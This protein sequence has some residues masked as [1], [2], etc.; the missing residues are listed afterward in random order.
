MINQVIWMN[1]MKDDIYEL[2]SEFLNPSYGKKQLINEVAVHVKEFFHASF[3]AFYIFNEQCNS[4]QLYT[5]ATDIDTFIPKDRVKDMLEFHSFDSPVPMKMKTVPITVF[6][7]LKAVL[8]LGYVDDTSLHEEKV[9]DTS[10]QNHMEYEYGYLYRLSIQLFSENNRDVILKRVVEA[11]SKLYPDYTYYLLLSQDSGLSSDLPV[12]QI[13]FSDDVTKS[14]SAQVYM[15]GEFQMEDRIKER[16]TYL[17]APLSGK[18]GV[19]GV[20]QI[21]TD[22]ITP[23]SARHLAFVKEFARL[24][25]IALERVILYENS[26]HQVE[27]LSLVNEFSQKLNANLDL[28]EIIKIIKNEI[29][30]I[31]HAEEVGFV[32]FRE[33]EPDYIKIRDESTDYFRTEEGYSFARYLLNIVLENEEPIF[34]GMFEC[35]GRTDFQS[36][37]AIPMDTAFHKGVAVILHQNRYHF[38]FQTFKLMEALI[39]H[40]TLAVTNTLLKDELHRSVITDYLTKLYSRNYLEEK[41]NE[42]MEKGNRGVLLLFDIDN[43]KNINDQYGHHV[44]DQVIQQVAHILKECSREKDIPARWGGEELAIYLPD[45]SIHFGLDIANKIREKVQRKT[46]PNVTVSC[47]VSAWT[48][49]SNDTTVELFLRSDQA[50]YEAKSLGKNRVIQN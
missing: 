9:L 37:I 45:E 44:G 11:L 26:K 14:L 22:T 31:S 47:G 3:S 21:I 5:Y 19:Y 35:E 38:T 17:Y 40:A 46:N 49:E 41:I 43:F 8:L 12:K 27:T 33:S 39:Q 1:N 48:E 42:N 2:L 34:S 23:F 7:G 50:L 32:Y 28:L 4:F 6:D 16:R 20:L 36:V 15:T 10:N 25:G 24:A 18:Q 13:Q 30:T 29:L